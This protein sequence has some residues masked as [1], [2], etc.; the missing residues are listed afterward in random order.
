M[1]WK[2]MLAYVT[3]AVDDEL[4]RRTFDDTLSDAGVGPVRLPPR[5]PNLNPHA[6]RWV[7]SVKEVPSQPL[8]LISASTGASD[9]S[10]SASGSNVIC[11]MWL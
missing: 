8:A 1:D 10:K 3:G 2:T 4:L 7:K 6:E 5:S 11:A 9:A